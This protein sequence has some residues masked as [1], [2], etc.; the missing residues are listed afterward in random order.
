MTGNPGQAANGSESFAFTP[1]NLARAN[2]LIARY[3]EG[4]QASA[5]MALLDLAQRQNDGWLPRAAI[6]H[7]AGVLNMA[8]IRVYEVATFYSMYNLAPVG[9]HFVPSLHHDGR[10]N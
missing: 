8:L 2:A 5:V 10:V 4:R 1:E 6:D 3:P 7:V 9:R